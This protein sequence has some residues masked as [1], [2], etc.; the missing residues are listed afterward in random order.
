[1]ATGRII[2]SSKAEVQLAIRLGFDPADFRTKATVI[3]GREFVTTRSGSDVFASTLR[4]AGVFMD[5]KGAVTFDWQ[6]YDMG[7]K[8]RVRARGPWALE[9]ERLSRIDDVVSQLDDLAN[10]RESLAKDILR[11]K[12]E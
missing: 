1:M 7:P 8:V 3:C 12:S 2:V 9:L 4:C 5:S 11:L 10:I 6:E